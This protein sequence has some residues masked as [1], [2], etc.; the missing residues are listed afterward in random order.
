MN[1]TGVPIGHC[2]TTIFHCVRKGFSTFNLLFSSS[3]LYPILPHPQSMVFLFLTKPSNM[4]EH[5]I[6]VLL[7]FHLLTARA[8]TSLVTYANE[9]ENTMATQ[10]PLPPVQ[11]QDRE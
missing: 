3:S 1:G 8:K 7:A 6:A 9:D 10:D 11:H 4:K 5:T 2:F